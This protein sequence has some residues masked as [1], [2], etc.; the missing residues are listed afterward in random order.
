M[1]GFAHTQ[2]YASVVHSNA[3][4]S[5]F[6][7]SQFYAFDPFLIHVVSGQPLRIIHDEASLS[8]INPR[9]FRPT[10]NNNSCR[11]LFVHNQ[12][13]ICSLFNFRILQSRE[14]LSISHI[15]TS[16]YFLCNIRQTSFQD[17]FVLLSLLHRYLIKRKKCQ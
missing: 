2:F 5:V 1:K 6:P 15:Q 11:G 9:H 8:I 3:L 12:F 13:C 14:D 10:Y 16:L 7:A 17:S 4:Q